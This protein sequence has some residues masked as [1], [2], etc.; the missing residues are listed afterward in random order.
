MSLLNYRTDMPQWPPP[1]LGYLLQ[2]LRPDIA[3]QVTGP[4]TKT[5]FGP[6]SSVIRHDSRWQ[7]EILSLP[8]DPR[9]LEA[10]FMTSGPIS[11]TVGWIGRHTPPGLASTAATLR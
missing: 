7:I 3:G 9:N 11:L 5:W 8:F 4:S 2:G 6:R 1:R 10:C